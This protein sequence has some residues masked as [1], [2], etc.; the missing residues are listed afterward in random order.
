MSELKITLTQLDGTAEHPIRLT[1]GDTYTITGGPSEIMRL[2][3]LTKH[4][5]AIEILSPHL[6]LDDDVMRWAAKQGL[7]KL[8]LSDILIDDLTPPPPPPVRKS[9]V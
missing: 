8:R 7:K 5:L 2:T 6:T 4:E 9:G 1:V 3:W